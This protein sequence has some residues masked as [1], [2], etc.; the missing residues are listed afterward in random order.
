MEIQYDTNGTE[1]KRDSVGIPISYTAPYGNVKKCYF[2][3]LLEKKIKCTLAGQMF[4]TD[5]AKL[6][7]FLIGFG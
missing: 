6:G 1:F 2:E 4:S 3:N 7:I 5:K